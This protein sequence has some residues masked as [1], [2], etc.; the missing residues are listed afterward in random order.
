MK[1]HW[2]QQL[3]AGGKGKFLTMQDIVN[4]ERRK[5]RLPLFVGALTLVSAG[6]IGWNA[7]VTQSGTQMASGNSTSGGDANV[8][9]VEAPLRPID[10][11]VLEIQTA[12]KQ[13]NMYNGELDG[14]SGPAT[15][16]AVTGYQT[17][18]GLA[19]S[20]KPDENVL[21]HIQF[22]EKLE[23]AA[24]YTG[25]TTPRDDAPMAVSA[26]VASAQPAPDLSLVQKGLAELG[27]Q[28]GPVDGQFGEMTRKAIREF[29]RDRSL[30]VTGDLSP[31]LSAEL[32]KVTGKSS[33]SEM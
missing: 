29:Q 10:Q 4:A 25:S 20:G 23:Q 19:P 8:Q 30:P 11:T 17:K 28:P 22:N 9:L 21:A 32:A 3:E 5:A 15:R 31:Q 1:P 27:Y 13:M 14:L 24:Q 26:A 33:L 7:L 2:A 16:N 12:L 18:H 6:V